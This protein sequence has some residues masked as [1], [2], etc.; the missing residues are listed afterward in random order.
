MRLRRL[1]KKPTETVRVGGEAAE[2]HHV[3]LS[4]ASPANP[5]PAL[6]STLAAAEQNMVEESME[7]AQLDDFAHFLTGVSAG[8]LKEQARSLTS[9]RRKRLRERKLANREEVRAVERVLD[10]VIDT[11]R[12]FHAAQSV[13]VDKL[14]AQIELTAAVVAKLRAR[15]DSAVARVEAD[16]RSVSAE[17][18]A[19]Q[20]RQ[21]CVRAQAK[22]LASSPVSLA[23]CALELPQ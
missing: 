17:L 18:E 3:V 14:R 1:S 15:R 5:A 21:L 23:S 8:K 19:V 9:V 4:L 7:S 13:D 16:L 6:S 22:P 10:V 20:A 2:R 11:F 12:D